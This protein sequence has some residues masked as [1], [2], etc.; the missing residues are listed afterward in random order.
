MSWLWKLMYTKGYWKN[1]V[2][3]GFFF[4][5]NKFWV[6]PRISFSTRNCSLDYCNQFNPSTSSFNLLP[7][8]NILMFGYQLFKTILYQEYV[9]KKWN[10]SVQ[11]FVSSKLLGFWC[12][13]GRD[14]TL[15]TSKNIMLLFLDR[16][17]LNRFEWFF[18]R[19]SLLPDI[20]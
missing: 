20:V 15:K 12:H 2:F 5:T 17:Q 3:L 4:Q 10:K 18:Q 11:P 8:R 19:C 1:K 7:S 6:Y 16:W 14:K 9:V 13:S